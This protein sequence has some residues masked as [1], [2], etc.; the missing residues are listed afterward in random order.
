MEDA[1]FVGESEFGIF[2]GVSGAKKSESQDGLYSFMLCGI[3][4][5]QIESQ[6][7]TMPR[8]LYLVIA[9]T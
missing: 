4:Q 5:R 2:D 9:S 6:K 1:W 3:T 8:Y 7:V